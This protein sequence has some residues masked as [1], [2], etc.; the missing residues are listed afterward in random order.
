MFLKRSGLWFALLA[1]IGSAVMVRGFNS[2]PTF[3]DSYYHFNAARSLAQGEGFVDQYL[4]VYL[5]AADSLPA[6]SHYYWMPLTSV[7]AAAG[8]WLFGDSFAMAQLGFIAALW[9]A[10]LLAY[11]IAMRLG[12]SIRHA[13]FAGI[14]TLLGAF[15]GR[16][17]GTTDTFAPYAFIG[18]GTLLLMARG[19]EESRR[20]WL[21][22]IL[23]GIGSG[24][25]HLTR[26]DGLLMPI[27]GLM[28]LFWP[29]DI[30]RRASFDWSTRIVSAGLFLLSYLIVMLPW[31]LRNLDSTGAIL[32]I[33]GTQT[34][35][36]ANYD[37]LFAYP[38][39]ATMEAF[40]ADGAGLFI[41]SRIEGL[42]SNF[43]TLIAVE[44][45]IALA[46]FMFIGLWLRRQQT[47]LRPVMLFI[48]G[49]HLAFTFVFTYP[50]IRG[51][52]FHGAAALV[53][54]WSA[55]A[56]IGLDHSVTWL[57]KRRSHW[58]PA[59]ARVVFTW[60]MVG[61]IAM[62]TIVISQTRDQAAADTHATY[63]YLQDNFPAGTRFMSNNPAEL[64][65]HTGLGG[66]VIPNEDPAVIP[67]IA[68]QYGIDYLL[69]Q[70]PNYPQPMAVLFETYP[71]FLNPLDLPLEGVRIYAILT[72]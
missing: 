68:A 67:G 44:G 71:D 39:G 24:L 1:L 41:E 23:A 70:E 65:Y 60:G 33:G 9:G 14:V 10:S 61:I 19:M 66:V 27:V 3:T 56:I 7:L 50:G 8:M 62:L 12:G 49:L 11:A 37:A 36:L 16:M 2:E 22:W 18:A 63:A 6:P 72:D 47:F 46:P 29:W 25:A 26:S 69:L 52:L 28:V 42:R 31:F 13:W 55:L 45:S 20:V 59:T 38:P 64:F 21:W 40:F 4:W 54:W 34:I 17:W 5:G 57:A 30:L 51:G 43:L 58:N 35:W 48:L 15:F 32:P 53:P